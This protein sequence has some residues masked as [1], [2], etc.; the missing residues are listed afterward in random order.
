MRGDLP[1]ALARF[2]QALAVKET[3][4]LHLRIGALQEKL[5]HLVDALASYG[6]GL[7]KAPGLPAV[8]KI[9]GD[10][11][12]ALKPRVPVLTVVVALPPPDLSVT[13]D[14][15]PLLPAA[16]GS[17]L[18]LDPGQH[19]VHASAAGHVP[20]DQVITLAEH[21][22][23]RVD[24]AL[25]AQEVRRDAPPPPPPS[26]LPG[27]LIA[28][29]AGAVLVTGVALFALSYVKDA[30]INALCGGPARLSCPKSQEAAILGDV[31]SVDDMRFVGA[32]LGL[33]GLGGV[34]AGAY[35]LVRG[36]R[37]QGTAAV[38]VFP[39]TGVG[40]VGVG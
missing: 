10:Q 34:A 31:S 35:L 3:A 22:T 14:G 38:R 29:G 19:R 18:P 5:G 37:A 17:A 25:V 13:I 20:F 7:E 6:R 26:K 8:A 4:Q 40:E 39:V 21:D 9:A 15:A 2:Q 33:A 1:T 30:Q 28:G 32:G 12:A 36:S 27:A 24:V 16:L 23:R 11:M